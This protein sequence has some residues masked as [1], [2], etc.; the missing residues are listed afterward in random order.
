MVA[1]GQS[2]CAH[3]QSDIHTIAP[4]SG[5]KVSIFFMTFSLVCVRLLLI[6]FLVGMP[7]PNRYDCVRLLALTETE[8]AELIVFCS[9]RF[10]SLDTLR[11]TYK[12]N[13]FLNLGVFV[14]LHSRLMQ[15]MT[16]VKRGK[17]TQRVVE[18]KK[19]HNVGI[20]TSIY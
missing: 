7:K 1:G 10:F 3:A 15:M 16:K 4:Q 9:F 13:R 12:F 18:R 2:S 19:T 17:S 8:Q 11:G 5:I 6:F 20:L 14:S